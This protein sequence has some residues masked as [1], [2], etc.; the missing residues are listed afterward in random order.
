MLVIIAALVAIVAFVAGL[1]VGWAAR[2]TASWC[3]DCGSTKDCTACQQPVAGRLP[4][5]RGARGP[6]A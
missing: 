5:G 3:P 6:H 4:R 1:A 2:G